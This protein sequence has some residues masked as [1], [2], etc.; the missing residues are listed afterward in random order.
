MKR[1]I[2]ILFAGIAIGVLIGFAIAPSSRSKRSA[3]GPN[4]QPTSGNLSVRKSDNKV[5][6]EKDGILLG[7]ITTVPFQELY[8]VLSARSPEEIAQ[9]VQQLRELPPGKE[10]NAK[11]VTFFKAWAHLDAKAALTAAISFKSLEAKDTAIGAVLDGADTIVAGSL[12][13]SIAALPADTLSPTLQ[14]SLLGKA[15]IKWSQLDPVAAAKFLDASPIHGAGLM[16]ARIS[17]AEN[18]STTDPQGALAWAEQQGDGRDA[19]L[20]RSAAITGWWHTDPRA[21]EAYVLSHLDSLGP[22]TIMSMTR[23]V[24]SQDPQ[25][26]KEWVTQMPDGDARRSATSYIAVNLARTD[27]KGATE[28]AASL[29]DDV[30]ERALNGT[31]DQWFRKDPDAAAQWVDGLIGKPRDEAISAYSLSLSNKSPEAAL[32]WATGIADA[33]TRDMSVQRIVGR[34]LNR[35]PSDAIS[36]IQ[37]STLSDAEKSHLLAIPHGR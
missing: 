26:A 22:E 30:R 27:P 1:S 8:G 35:S 33:K 31:V 32:G 13:A 28:W 18:W 25:R 7:D 34:W 15:L 17:I 21:A 20:A 2:G 5:A 14:T 6:P 4:T 9:L 3:S 10:T 29:P 24:V 12:A 37:S 36:W 11:I 19:R 23:Q 16:A